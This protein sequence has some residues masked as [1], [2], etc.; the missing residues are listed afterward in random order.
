MRVRVVDGTKVNICVVVS[1]AMP[2][3]YEKVIAY[4]QAY[5]NEAGELVPYKNG[6]AF[7]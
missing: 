4:P 7:C 2:V 1:M 6:E 3:T 5:V